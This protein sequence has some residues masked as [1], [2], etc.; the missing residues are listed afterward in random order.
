MMQRPMLI[1]FD[2]MGTLLRHRDSR[3]PYWYRL[4]ELVETEGIMS[5]AK[6]NELYAAWRNQ[7]GPR[8]TREVTLKKRLAQVAPDLSDRLDILD[9]LVNTFMA[10]YETKTE[11]C[12][13]VEKM[14]EAWAGTVTMGVVSNFF[15][16]HYPERLLE[17]HGLRNHL[18]FVIDSAQMGYRKPAPEI[19]LT[20]LERGGIAERDAAQVI[21]VGDDWI[22][23]IEG[24]RQLGIRPVFYSRSESSD[25]SVRVIHSW[26][27]FRP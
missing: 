1:L 14:F 20:A 11:L 16:P 9:H 27:E 2:M 18:D 10:E 12:D 3:R 22:A 13:G 23:D 6:F 17:R 21:F 15:V 25:D 4:G 19:Y 24:S 5:S 8:G 7:R 26:S